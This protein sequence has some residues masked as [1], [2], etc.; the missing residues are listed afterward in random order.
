M[1]STEETTRPW[2]R[3]QDWKRVKRM[4]ISEVITPEH[5]VI[6][7]AAASKGKLLQQLS[8]KAAHHLNVSAHDIL[9]ALER[10]EALGSTGIGAGIAIPHAPVAGTERP[11]GLLVRLNKPIEFEALDDEPVDIVC[12]VL[13]PMEWN[14]YSLK[15]LSSIARK[16]R[17]TESIKLI[18]ESNSLDKIYKEITR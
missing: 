3:G 8:E 13:T 15:L 7:V 18:R 5:V 12:L 16:L 6:G 2:P 10:R 9:T 14:S 1:R 4:K 11:F 17:S